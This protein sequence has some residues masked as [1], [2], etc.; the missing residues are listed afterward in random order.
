MDALG[1]QTVAH[2]S[3][4]AS[5]RNAVIYSAM[6][7]EAAANDFLAETTGAA[8]ELFEAL[9]RLPTVKKLL[10]GPQAVLARNRRSGRSVPSGR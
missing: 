4:V 7:C 9:D 10:A 6:A 5:L 2:R 1:L 3:Q 8:T